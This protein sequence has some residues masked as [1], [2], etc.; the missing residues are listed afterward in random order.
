MGAELLRQSG[1]LQ[2]AALRPGHRE[3]ALGQR[4]GLVKDYDARLGQRL[5]II[6]ALDQ[7]TLLGRAADAAEKAQ[8][9]GNH[10]GAGAGHHQEV[11]RA[12]HPHTPLPT[13]EQRGEDRQ[14]QGGKDDDGGIVPGEFGNKM[15]RLGFFLTGVFDQV[16]NPGNCRFPKG[17]CDLYMEQSR[18]IHAPGNHLIALGHVAGQRFAGEGGGVQR[19]AALR[20]YAVQRDA[21]PGLDHDG[22]AHRNFLRVHLDQ[23]AVPL[24]VG[25]VGAYVH[26]ISNRLAAPAD[27]YALEQLAH[28][29]EQQD[30]YA[31]RVLPAAESAQRRYRHQEIFVEHLAVGDVPDRFPNHV[32]AHYGVGDQKERQTKKTFHRQQQ[33]AYKQR[34]ADKNAVEHLF[35][36]FGHK[37]PSSPL[38]QDN[39][40]VRLHLAA[41]FYDLLHDGVEPGVVPLYRHFL[42]H[43]AHGG[44]GHAVDFLN[45]GFHLRGA[46]G[47]VQ[48]N[49]LVGLFHKYAPLK[50]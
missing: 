36:L 10:Q 42:A 40:T 2:H 48:V 7:D 47:T 15:L 50:F 41:D 9:N 43:E 23:L 1:P 29:I 17:F 49:Q 18:Q 12:G 31:L 37:W 4:A 6:A 28:L 22:I 33:S 27:R 39:F 25:V 26:Q 14:R 44:A 24:H 34:K 32:P 20:H 35:L 8:G 45:G 46:V 13:R 38:F 21:L 16:Q 11:Q 3:F 30:R 19:R 5:Q